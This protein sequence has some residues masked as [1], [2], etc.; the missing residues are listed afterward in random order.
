RS[1][2]IN[3]KTGVDDGTKVLGDLHLLRDGP[4]EGKDESNDLSEDESRDDSNVVDEPDKIS[5][6]ESEDEPE[7]DEFEVKSAE[8]WVR[9]V[10]APIEDGIGMEVKVAISNIKEDEE[11]FEAE[12][13]AGGTMKIA[14]DPLATGGISE[15]IGGDALDL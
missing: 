15:S 9:G 5:D 2:A 3:L 4:T 8:Y 1:W 13:S 14:V 12:A 6:E 11:K 10:G 7:E